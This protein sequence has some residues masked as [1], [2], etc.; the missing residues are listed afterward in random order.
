MHPVT[1]ARGVTDV[2]TLDVDPV[3]LIVLRQIHCRQLNY[4]SRTR[5]SLHPLQQQSLFGTNSCNAPWSRFQPLIDIV[6]IQCAIPSFRFGKHHPTMQCRAIPPQVF[7]TLVNTHEVA[8][9]CTANRRRRDQWNSYLWSSP[10]KY[11]S[12]PTTQRSISASNMHPL[13]NGQTH[14]LAGMLLKRLQHHH[15][16]N[17]K[18][19]GKKYGNLYAVPP[20]TRWC[21]IKSDVKRLIYCILYAEG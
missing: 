1:S 13:L 15:R 20:S 21:R 7:A 10:A 3:T 9:P 2:E 12:T 5:R 11:G 17:T 4:L 8:L 16:R 19:E 18:R 14:H 6:N